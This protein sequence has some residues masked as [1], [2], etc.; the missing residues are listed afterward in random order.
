MTPGTDEYLI[1]VPLFDEVR[2]DT[3][4]RGAFRVR[5]EGD[6]SYVAGAR[7]DGEE[8]TRSFLRHHEIGGGRE[9]VL[10]LA[11]EPGASWGRATADRP[12][13]RV[14]GARV[15]AAPFVVAE[16]DRF[17]DSLTIEL[18]SAEPEALIRYTTDDS[19]WRDADGPIELRESTTLRFYAELRG[20][21][22]PV[23]ESYLHRIPNEWTVDLETEPHPQYTAGGAAVLVDGLRGD[24]DW[25]TGGWMGFQG[26][27]LTATVDLGSVQR[28]RKLG[29]SFLQ[30]NRPWI[31]MPV[32]VVLSTS[33]D[34]EAFAEAGR[35]T[36]DV[37][38]DAPGVILRDMTIEPDRPVEAR[39]VRLEATTFGT[40][41]DWHLGHGGQGYIFIDE[42]L[43]ELEP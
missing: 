17:R 7:L 26:K 33:V 25:R 1:G 14:E 29:G 36:T 19:E 12:T 32:D 23:V 43:V 21:K 22:S 28:V 35:L 4:E 37:A 39:F 41:P 30:E 2:I 11:D 34:G 20:S 16:S 42:I 9:L 13:S 27:D 5:T 40:I 38:E 24:P 31:W 15:L 18:R 10:T 8:L 3:G 6:G